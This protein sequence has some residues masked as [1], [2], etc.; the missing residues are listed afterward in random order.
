M[1]RNFLIISFFLVMLTGF[2]IIHPSPLS[3]QPIEPLNGADL[4]LAIKKLNVVGT[5]LY[6][7]AH[8]DDENTALMAY[9]A[10]GRM[11]RTGY[12]SVTRGSGGQNLIGSEKDNA[13]SILRT[14]EL[15]AARKIDGAEQFF[16]RAVDFGYSKSSQETLIKWDREKILA[17]MVWVIRSFRPDVIITRF[18][19]QQGGHGHHLA[20]ALLAAEAFLAA[21]DTGRFR[22]QLKW[23][24]PWQATR[25]VWNGWNLEKTEQDSAGNKIIKV[26][27]GEYNSLLGKSYLE[28]AA[29]A[30]SM[31]KS[32]GFGSAAVHGSYLNYFLHT[33]GIPAQKDLFDD[34]D[35]SWKR[36]PGSGPLEKISAGLEKKFDPVNPEQIIPDLLSIY[37]LLQAHRDDPFMQYKIKE[38]ERIIPSCAGL[39]LEAIAIDYSVSPGDT[40]FYTCTLINRSHYPVFLRKIISP[41]VN[42]DSSMNIALK[43]NEPFNIKLNFKLP[44]DSP[45]GYPYW[46]DRYLGEDAYPAADLSLTGLPVQPDP[47]QI[48]IRLALNEFPVDFYLPVY[49]RWADR[50]KGERYRKVMIAPSVTANLD[51]P[52]LIFPNGEPKNISLHLKNWKKNTSGSVKVELPPGWSCEPE[53]TVYQFTDKLEEK[54]VRFTIHTQQVAA[55]GTLRI[56]LR[57]ADIT[58]SHSY[59]TIE[60]DHFPNQLFFP[61]AEI[62]LISLPI[63][64]GKEKIGYVMGSGDEIPDC[65]EQLGYPVKLISDTELQEGNYSAYDVVITGTRAYNSRGIL[66]TVKNKLMEYVRKGGTLITLH[67]TRFGLKADN[68]GPYPIKISDERVSVEEAPVVFLQPDH[69]LLNRPN[70]ITARDFDD[71]VQERGLYFAGEWDDHF[72]P[73]LGCN[74]PGEKLQQGGLLYTTYGKGHFIYSGYSWFRQLPAGVPG[75]LRLFVNMISIGENGNEKF[76]N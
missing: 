55:S 58:S 38:L 57:I 7:A 74:D 75:A 48:H 72:L 28:V 31:H 66:P 71:W 53:S 11:M 40:L 64:S 61:P 51:Q 46:L 52:I 8:P 63:K 13:L 36:I 2:A 54:E 39:W 22:E 17:D 10:K 68:I 23:V 33:A 67:N 12:L 21:A 24:Q 19:P 29:M 30:R 1:N 4:R 18:S 44:P 56:K 16:T 26:D 9:L 14:Q 32:Q 34:I 73:I 70:P 5:V 65:L 35:L 50:V 41:L 3:A 20:S 15:L 47:L 43:Y 59:G 62:R 42:Q 76:S 49:Y 25:M 27:V 60:Y 37:N 45:I 69:P 6:I